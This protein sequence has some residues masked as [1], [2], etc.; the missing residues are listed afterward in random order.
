MPSKQ[1][2]KSCIYA[3]R[4]QPNPPCPRSYTRR[5]TVAS[6]SC[7]LICGILADNST[8]PTPGLKNNSACAASTGFTQ[9]F[10]E[11]E[12]GG[13]G[14]SPRDVVLGYL[15]LSS[16][17]LTTTFVITQRSGACSRIAGAEN[18][19]M[20][21]ALLPALASGDSFA[22][23]G[24][25]HLT[26]SG[27]HLARPLLR[28]YPQ[29]GGYRLDGASPWVTGAKHAE[30]VVVGAVVMDDDQPTEQ[31]ILA[32]VPADLAGVNVPDPVRLVALTGSCT[33]R[34]ELSDA[35]VDQRQVLAGPVENVMNLGGGGTTGGLQTST[36]ALGLS[37][38]A[39]E[40]MAEES[41]RRDE[42]IPSRDAL[43]NDFNQTM[44]LLMA[45][46]D[47]DPDCS[48]ELVRTRANSLALRT[49]QAA[50]VAAKGAGFVRGHP[51]GRWCREALFFLVWS[52]PQPVVSANLCELAGILE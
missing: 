31:Q 39:L 40:F 13:Q 42:L 6:S 32:V 11:P 15:A 38:A 35:F 4:L 1:Q 51:A 18:H 5:K 44:Q 47:G 14:W 50:L 45:A 46:V 37:R 36:L 7:A 41:S 27:R 43:E 48:K 29:D 8:T 24:I 22:T 34:F 17:C 20:K 10:I 33:G 16:A 30:R 12:Y 23:I 3:Y 49:T 26:T 2:F 19:A 28:A 52:C 25:S 21:E 9:W